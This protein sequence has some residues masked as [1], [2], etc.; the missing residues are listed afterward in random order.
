MVKKVGNPTPINNIN[1]KPPKVRKKMPLVKSIKTECTEAIDAFTSSHQ[2]ARKKGAKQIPS[3]IKGVSGFAKKV[4]PIPFATATLGFL[5]FLPGATTTGLV[6]GLLAKKGINS[7][8]NFISK[9]LK[10]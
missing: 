4:G 10:K 3:I 6:T 5:S 9:L 1:N 7:G 2:A 8:V